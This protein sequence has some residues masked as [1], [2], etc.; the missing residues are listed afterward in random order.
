M[1]TVRRAGAAF[2]SNRSFV[3]KIKKKNMQAGPASRQEQVVVRNGDD[4]VYGSPRLPGATAEPASSR[5]YTLTQVG[6]ESPSQI[7]PKQ[8]LRFSGHSLCSWRNRGEKNKKKQQKA[9]KNKTHTHR[10]EYKEM[11]QRQQP[12]QDSLVREREEGSSAS[13]STPALQ[14][15]LS[16]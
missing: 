3:I 16:R 12:T 1:P 9:E 10:T 11:C 2:H 6:P 15:S 4:E 7:S 14:S 13:T 5:T 8:Y